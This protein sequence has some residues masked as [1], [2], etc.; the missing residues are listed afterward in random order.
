MPRVWVV[1]RGCG[2]QLGIP[3]LKPRHF[4]HKWRITLCSGQRNGAG[5]H[6]TILEPLGGQTALDVGACTLKYTCIL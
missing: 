3:H 1:E 6:S 5:K 4:I 2:F